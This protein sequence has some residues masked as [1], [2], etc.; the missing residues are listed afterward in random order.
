MQ[1][2]PASKCEVKCEVWGPEG[3]TPPFCFRASLNI[4]NLSQA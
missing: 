3:L 2:A 1:A 4:I